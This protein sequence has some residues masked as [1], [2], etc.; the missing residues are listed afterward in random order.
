MLS[1]LIVLQSNLTR[2]TTRISSNNNTK[3][4]NKEVGSM[5]CAIYNSAR[6]FAIQE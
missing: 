2:A 4:V 6:N 1:A 5:K 3:E